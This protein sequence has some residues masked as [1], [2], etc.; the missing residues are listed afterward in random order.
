MNREEW[1]LKVSE[2]KHQKWSQT[3]IVLLQEDL[4]GSDVVRDRRYMA[5]SI[6]K[7]RWYFI[8]VFISQIKK[9]K[10]P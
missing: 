8:L 7:V 1:G 5:V 6:V 4:S 2:N 9:K 10:F 3:L